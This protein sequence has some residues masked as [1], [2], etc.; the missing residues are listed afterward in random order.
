MCCC[1][2]PVFTSLQRV[3]VAHATKNLVYGK[4]IAHQKVSAFSQQLLKLSGEILH[5]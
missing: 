3:A 1:H 4:K 2:G 5:I